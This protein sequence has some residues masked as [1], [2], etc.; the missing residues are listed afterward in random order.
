MRRL[1]RMALLGLVLLLVALASALTAMRFAIHGREVTTPK[2]AGMTLAKAENTLSDAGLLLETG[3]SF[4]SNDIPEGSVL[5]QVP[6]AGTIV[7]RGWRVRVALSLGQARLSVPDVM[8]QS[9]RAGEINVRRRGL[10]VGNI[11]V[12]HLPGLPA[13]QV[14]AESPPPDT[15]GMSSPKVNLL[16]TAPEDQQTL[17][18]P[19]FTGKTVGEAATA[20]EGAG[21]KLTNSPN[22][23]NLPPASS[24][25]P[26]AAKIVRQ[27]PAGG[28]EVAPGDIVTL[29]IAQPNPPEA[30][31]KTA[32]QP[33]AAQP[34]PA[35][36]TPQSKPD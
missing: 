25:L 10:E 34:A 15:R 33:A 22:A 9:A 35:P 8:G 1:F 31:E 20:I 17:L 36:A 2:L 26:A 14:V 27:S 6:A 18:M 19:D 32:P 21:L 12:V 5:S 11:A 4:F 30:T 23:T 24:R 3:D 16:V 28:Q 29:E 13:D 7:R